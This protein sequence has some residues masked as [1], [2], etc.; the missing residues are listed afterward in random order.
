MKCGR[1]SVSL[2]TIITPDLFSY[3]FSSY[4]VM[5]HMFCVQLLDCGE[6]VCIY[7]FDVTYALESQ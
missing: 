6:N 3:I 2:V 4:L 7:E 5:V 1:I